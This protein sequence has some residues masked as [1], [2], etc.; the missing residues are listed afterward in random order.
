[1]NSP[2][3]SRG[4]TQRYLQRLLGESGLA[5]RSSLGQCFL[6][7]LNLLD[8]LVEA[9]ELERSDF[10]LEVGA[11]TGSLTQRLAAGAGAV[12]SVEIDRG[13]Y[14]LAQHSI[15]PHGNVRLLHEDILERKNALNP[16]VMEA[17]DSAIRE[18]SPSRLKVVANLPYVVAT[19]VIS[20]LLTGPRLWDR[21][22]VTIQ[23]ELADRLMARPGT[24][25]YGSFSVM[26]AAVGDV[27]LL[28]ELSGSVFWPRPRVA[29]AFVRIRPRAERRDA[30]RN[31]PLFSQFTR[32][33]MIHRRKVLRS[34][35]SSACP[36]VPKPEIDAFLER[37]GFGRQT[38]AESLEAADFV[39]LANEI[40]QQWVGS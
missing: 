27:E 13:L 6:I 36:R 25:D 14:G 21:M 11:G 17:C 34:A 40:P 5:P 8:L 38:R 7:D 12:V 10:V 26:A 9:A 29:S 15:E 33:V 19:P 39:R 20:L 37:L 32:A 1:M 24:K 23:K 31:L 28:R 30:I 18:T 16:A 35:M 3:A 2:G 4:H 22:V